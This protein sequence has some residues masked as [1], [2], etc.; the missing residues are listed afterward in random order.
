[1]TR[2]R[3]TIE[4]DGAGF[5]GWQRQANGL[6]VQQAL[7][8]AVTAFSGETVTVIAA[9]RTD[10]GVHALGQVVHVELVRPTAPDTLLKAL[11]AHLRPLRVSVVAAAAVPASFHARFS[12]RA[13]TYLYRILNR[14]APPTLE[15]GRV[16]HVAKPLNLRAMQ[17]GARFLIGRHDF[18]TFRSSHCQATS[19]VKTLAALTVKRQGDEV[20]IRARARSFLHNQVRSIVGTL[21]RVGDGGWAPADVAVA[22]A[23]RDRAASGPVAPAH[24]LYLVEVSYRRSAQQ[25]HRA[26]VEQ[27]REQELEDDQ[28]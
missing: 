10:A 8:Q 6:A 16:W 24:G 28:A 20:L 26:E 14:P 17:Q 12:A 27:Q 22:L 25:L 1:V 11:N 2:F 15:S 13:R 5:V 23:A 19:P 21:K 18:T 4:Y 3:L 9:G 7:E